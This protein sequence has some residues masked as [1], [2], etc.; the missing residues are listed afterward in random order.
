VAL[1]REGILITDRD[2]RIRSKGARYR[3]PLHFLPVSN[4]KE[5]ESPLWRFGLAQHGA[6]GLLIHR[7]RCL[8]FLPASN[9]EGIPSR[10]WRVPEPHRVARLK[11]P[12]RPPRCLETTVVY[13]A[14][15]TP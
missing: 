7:W 9:L 6:A 2:I 4:W 8:S 5:F 1:A 15:I 3:A 11:G 10:L 12:R 13:E 14:H